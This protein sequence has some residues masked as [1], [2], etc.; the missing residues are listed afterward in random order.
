MSSGFYI[1]VRLYDQRRR[2]N[3]VKNIIDTLYCAS[4]YHFHDDRV[5]CF[6][7]LNKRTATQN[8]FDCVTR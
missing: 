4:F 5:I 1:A 8:P 3:V 2:L 6:L 7:I